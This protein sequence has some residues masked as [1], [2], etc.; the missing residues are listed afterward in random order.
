MVNTA[1][2]NTTQVGNTARQP[3]TKA[4]NKTSKCDN[5]PKRGKNTRANKAKSNKIADTGNSSVITE[6]NNTIPKHA[7]EPNQNMS[8]CAQVRRQGRTKKGESDGNN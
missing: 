8:D 4:G 3:S 7:S 1:I 6:N 5:I 2:E